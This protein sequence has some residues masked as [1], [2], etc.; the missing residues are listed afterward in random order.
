MQAAHVNLILNIHA[1][2]LEISKQLTKQAIDIF[3]HVAP[4]PLNALVVSRWPRDVTPTIKPAHGQHVHFIHSD[5]VVYFQMRKQ[6][7]APAP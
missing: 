6:A 3:P 1:D 5:C 4:Q 2:R 7:T